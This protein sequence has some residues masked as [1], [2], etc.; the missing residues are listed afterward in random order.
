MSQTA[1]WA[2]P[3]A[4][5]GLAMRNTVN[6]ILDV[7]RSSSS[8]AAA[9]SPT[10]AGMFW[11]DES[12]SPAVLRIRNSS[13][14]AWIRIIDTADAGSSRSAIGASPVETQAAGVGQ[15]LPISSSSGLALAT[16]TGGAWF[17]FAWRITDGGATLNGSHVSGVAA[18]GTVILAAS[19]G[20]QHIGFAKRLA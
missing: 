12:V 2:V 17:F 8:G 19:A 9:P 1:T 13:N 20:N 4:P 10:V 6:T 3:S 5:S 7:L 15:V 14:T 18:G 11:F 16:P